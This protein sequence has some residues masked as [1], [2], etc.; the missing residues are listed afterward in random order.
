MRHFV[1]RVVFGSFLVVLL[2]ACGTPGAPIPSRSVKAGQRP[3][4]AKPD[5]LRAWTDK[6]S[7]KLALAGFIERST[8]RDSADFIPPAERLAVFS[9]DLLEPGS[10][11]LLP[12]PLREAVAALRGAGYRICFVSDIDPSVLRTAARADG[13]VPA[14]EIIGAYPPADY[15]VRGGRPVIVPRAEAA[16]VAKPVVLHQALGLRPVLA[17]G[18]TAAD[19]PLLEYTALANPRPSLAFLVGR[20]VPPSLAAEAGRAGWLIVDPAADWEQTGR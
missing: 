14:E 16:R 18:R 8:A 1:P 15:A 6:T 20:P 5:Q 10:A 19:L 2:A 13:G 7:A 3:V 4:S 11:T 12:E 9:A 17:F